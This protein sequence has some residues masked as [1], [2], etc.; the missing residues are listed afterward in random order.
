MRF[1]SFPVA[2]PVGMIAALFAFS[3][4]PAGAVVIVDTDF[5][6]DLAGLTFDVTDGTNIA[7]YGTG[8][9]GGSRGINLVDT[10]S[11]SGG[12]NS[13]VARFSTSTVFS[14]SNANQS[15]LQIRFDMAVTS[16]GTTSGANAVPRVLLRNSAA[17][18]QTLTIGFG[19]T[20]GNSILY[21]AR[22]DNAN[23]S[24]ALSYN[25]G[26]YNS[27]TLTEN[28]TNGYVTIAISL[29]HGGTTMN[30]TATQGSTTLFSG[31]VT[32]FTGNNFNQTNFNL[33]SATGQG[34]TGSLYVDNL[35]IQAVPEP[36]A[37]LLLL[38]CIGL[39][40]LRRRR[41]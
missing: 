1:A 31:D 9:P 5:T 35:F 27:T 18:S 10:T 6:N 32:G 29:L 16:L 28:D 12:T 34:G 38:S 23:P 14:T 2:G 26:A 36:T 17:P 7:G 3:L 4:L 11:A 25:F 19:L 30:V 22:G 40:S 15:E 24:T 8:G 33:N 13:T 39:G 41:A 37:A 20:G 21:A